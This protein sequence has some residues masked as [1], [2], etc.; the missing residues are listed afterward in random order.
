[1]AM[2]ATPQQEVAST[3]FAIFSDVEAPPLRVAAP[4]TPMKSTSSPDESFL[5]SGDG[6]CVSKTPFS[7]LES[8]PEVA[9]RAGRVHV[10]PT[11]NGRDGGGEDSPQR[12][13]PR[14]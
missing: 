5:A 13:E 8:S 1:M 6:R 9:V 7:S 10:S 2:T 12:D 11:P 3:N 4:V 14:D